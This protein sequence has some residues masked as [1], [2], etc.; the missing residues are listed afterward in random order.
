MEEFETPAL[1]AI[2]DGRTRGEYCWTCTPHVVIDA[3]KRSGSSEM[4]YLDADLYFFRSPEILLKEFRASGASVLLTEHRY[5]PEYDQTET[6]G[7]Y[8]VQFI[9]FRSDQTGLEILNWWGDRCIEW[10]FARFE[11]GKFG[12]Q[13]Y[14]DDWT[15][16]FSGVHVLENIGG[17]VAPWN[18]TAY[19]VSAGP[20]VNGVP[21]VFFHFHNLKWYRNGWIDLCGANYRMNN[22]IVDFIYRYYV[23]ALDEAFRSVREIEPGFQGGLLPEMQ[24][25]RVFYEKLKRKLD[26]NFWRIKV[27]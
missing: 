14:L 18:M 26:G 9:T 4:T 13:K 25:W 20:M 27:S 22:A 2:K 7:I 17:G 16:R 5:A 6:S 12:D 19:R 10:C 23:H 8:C 11:E 21:V 1:L 15:T 3:L 24:G